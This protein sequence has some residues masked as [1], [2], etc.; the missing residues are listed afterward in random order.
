MAD[1]LPILQI[2]IPLLA[3]LLCLLLRQRTVVHIFA[4]AVCWST[5][6]MSVM[7]LSRILDHGAISYMLGNW[8]APWGIEYRLDV[9]SGFVLLFV[10][11][12]GALVLSSARWSLAGEL[13]A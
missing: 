5:F 12:M 2:V 8:A 7:L 13:R 10:S 4:V 3:A 6:A 11:G 1:H 9:L